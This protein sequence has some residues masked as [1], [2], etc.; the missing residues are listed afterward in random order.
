MEKINDLRE[1][2][3]IP[4]EELNPNSLYTS[5]NIVFKDGLKKIE[6]DKPIFFGRDTEDTLFVV[7]GNHR[8][9]DALTENRILLGKQVASTKLSIKN[10]PSFHLIK[11][12]KI[13]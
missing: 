3:N 8:A 11:D 12:L 10:D 13:V 6:K 2:E 9:F 1:F 7:D 4:T 5:E